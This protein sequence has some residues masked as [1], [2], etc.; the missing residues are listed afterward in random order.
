MINKP[1][2]KPQEVDESKKH[3]QMIDFINTNESTIK[4]FGMLANY[5]A[6]YRRVGGGVGGGMC[7]WWGCGWMVY[8][9][10]RALHR[11]KLSVLVY[12]LL[13]EYGIDCPLLH[14]SLEFLRDNSQLVCLDTAN[15][16]TMWCVNLEVQ[17]VSGCGLCIH[18]CGLYILG[19]CI[20]VH[21]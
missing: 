15:Y 10:L 13:C 4:K 11:G 17:E 16:L 14:C 20:N 5:D 8:M 9:C 12:W 19:A 21:M 7:G 3:E 1:K 18:G 2:P 6:R